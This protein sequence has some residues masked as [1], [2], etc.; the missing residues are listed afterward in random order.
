MRKR[1]RAAEGSLEQSDFPLQRINA[2]QNNAVFEITD[3]DDAMYVVKVMADPIRAMREVWALTHLQASAKNLVPE[4]FDVIV[5]SSGSTIFVLMERLIGRSIDRLPLTA[6]RIGEVI[7]A[8]GRVHAT[9][10]TVTWNAYRDLSGMV[11]HIQQLAVHV[12][13]TDPNVIRR[14]DSFVTMRS[15]KNSAPNRGLCSAE[16]TQTFR[17]S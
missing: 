9:K 12:V 5:S 2:G 6:T 1:L 16:V 10:P 17:T 13:G 15:S 8:I 14:W 7:E 11:E 3:H 4:V